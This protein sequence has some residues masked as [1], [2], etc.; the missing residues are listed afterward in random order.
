M[1]VMVGD[2]SHIIPSFSEVCIILIVMASRS[3]PL[4]VIVAMSEEALLFSFVVMVIVLLLAP[5]DGETVAHEEL[6][7]I[8]LLVL[9]VIVNSALSAKYVNRIKSVDT[10][11]AGANE[12]RIKVM[13]YAFIVFPSRAVTTTYI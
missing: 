1:A 8:V 5:D 6:L 12:E 4:T 9:E 3:V 7:V 13:V 2:K 10:V 11:K